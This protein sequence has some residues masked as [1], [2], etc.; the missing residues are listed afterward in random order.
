[1]LHLE[2]ARRARPCVCRCAPVEKLSIWSGSCKDSKV[3]NLF[4]SLLVHVSGAGSGVG[5]VGLG[6]GAL[7]ANTILSSSFLQLHQRHAPPDPEKTPRRVR[8]SGFPGNPDIPF[9]PGEAPERICAGKLVPST[10]PLITFPPPPPEQVC[11]KR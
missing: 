9:C 1:M 11:L 10:L 8:N 3:F 5:D 4:M 2:Y 7:H 6:V